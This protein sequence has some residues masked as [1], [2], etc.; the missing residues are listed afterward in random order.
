[1]QTRFLRPIVLRATRLMAV[2]IVLPEGNAG[3]GSAVEEVQ[4]QS[5]AALSES[6]HQGPRKDAGVW[7]QAEPGGVTNLVAYIRALANKK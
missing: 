4:K 7:R 5:D 6:D 3:Q 2:A 1:M